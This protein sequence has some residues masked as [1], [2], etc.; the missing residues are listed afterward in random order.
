MN[1]KVVIYAFGFLILFFYSFQF[2]S[3]LYFILDTR[4]EIGYLSDSLL[5]LEGMRP[6]F[7]HSPSGLSTWFGS[8]FVLFNF[9]FNFFNELEFTIFNLF[10]VFDKTLFFIIRIYLI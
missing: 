8:I 6:S 5:L 4:D 9:I 1:N 10:N 2:F 3:Y 7:S